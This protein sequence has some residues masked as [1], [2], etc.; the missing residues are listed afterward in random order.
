MGP[1]SRFGSAS[2]LL[3]G[4][5]E[6]ASPLWASLY[7]SDRWARPGS[8]RLKAVRSQEGAEWHLA[9]GLVA[10]ALSVMT[11][12]PRPLGTAKDTGQPESPLTWPQGGNIWKQSHPPRRLLPVAKPVL[13]GQPHVTAQ[14]CSGHHC[15]CIGPAG[16][17]ATRPCPTWARGPRV[18]GR[19]GRA[20]G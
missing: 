18:L 11:A 16:V 3:C 15:G 17:C 14:G 9:P 2:R 1:L 6:V 20:V 4:F 13:A 5:G 7:P 10:G 12:P 8:G 19:K